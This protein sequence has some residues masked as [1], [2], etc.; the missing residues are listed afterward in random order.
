MT[1]RIGYIN[2]GRA[3]EG[4]AARLQSLGCLA[5][6]HEDRSGSVLPA[7]LQF[8]SA[9]E[10]LFIP[11]VG[12]LSHP[13]LPSPQKIVDRMRSNGVTLHIVEGQYTTS[14][15]GARALSAVLAALEQAGAKTSLAGR[16][17]VSQAEVRRLHAA[18][19]R[20]TEIAR[21][22]QISRMTVWRKLRA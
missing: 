1:L 17:R 6:R 15:P 3:R 14:G 21:Q 16:E 9:G 11:S 19:L 20:P 7:I 10:E 5:V 8:M 13:N 4:V 2:G 18:G 12:D 22:L